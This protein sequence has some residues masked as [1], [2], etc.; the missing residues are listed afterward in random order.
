MS[1]LTRTRIAALPVIA[2]IATVETFYVTELGSGKST[3]TRATA[4]TA[5]QA[6]MDAIQDDAGGHRM[7]VRLNTYMKA[8][9]LSRYRNGA[10]PVGPVHWRQYRKSLW[11]SHC[12]GEA[13]RH[14][15]DVES[16]RECSH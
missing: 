9:L 10:G 11:Q 16:F 5:V 6:A 15:A 13:A 3:N 8:I 4:F 14:A 12:Q 2:P 1:L 7:I